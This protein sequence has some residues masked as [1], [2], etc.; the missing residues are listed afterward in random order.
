MSEM[1]LVQRA[2]R[3]LAQVRTNGYPNFD[4]LSPEDALALVVD[5]AQRMVADGDVERGL[6]APEAGAAI[7][8]A[9]EC[10]IVL[11]R[12][13]REVEVFLKH[14]GGAADLAEVPP[15]CNL[16]GFSDRHPGLRPT[17]ALRVAN[18]DDTVTWVAVCGICGDTWADRWTESGHR[19]ERR[20]IEAY[21][22]FY[23]IENGLNDTKKGE[24]GITWEGQ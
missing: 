14:R 13:Q 17:E 15:R 20:S 16:C 4:G 3:R 18:K 12:V 22:R 19:V 6:T 23:T 2:I 9:L 5:V 10:D 24:T 21:R 7:L 8:G 1:T 11:G